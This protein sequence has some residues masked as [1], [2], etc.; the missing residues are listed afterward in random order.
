MSPSSSPPSTGW[1]NHFSLSFGISRAMQC[2]KNFSYAVKIPF[3]LPASC[4]SFDVVFLFWFMH[5]VTGFMSQCYAIYIPFALNLSKTNIRDDRGKWPN[6]T[7]KVCSMCLLGE[8][9]LINIMIIIEITISQSIFCFLLFVQLFSVLITLFETFLV[10]ILLQN[11]E[12]DLQRFTL[13]IF[14]F[15]VQCSYT[16]SIP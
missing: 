8:K 2:V 9:K 10:C 7:M 11:Q 5:T 16:E 14:M 12:H 3:I 1:A 15:I 4:S 13:S 6:E